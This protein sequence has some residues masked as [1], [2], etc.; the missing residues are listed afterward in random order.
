MTEEDQSNL[1]LLRRPADP[2]SPTALESTLKRVI[3]NIWQQSLIDHPEDDLEESFKRV[4][5]RFYR[6]LPGAA[7]ETLTWLSEVSGYTRWLEK[8][9]KSIDPISLES[10]STAFLENLQKKDD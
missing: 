5:D 7:V 1:V 9:M 6:I 2:G 10:V 8:S 4:R 3:Y